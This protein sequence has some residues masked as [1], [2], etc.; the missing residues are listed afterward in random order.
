MLP[1]DQN[2]RHP[3]IFQNDKQWK[4]GVAPDVYFLGLLENVE[5]FLWPHTY[6]STRRVILQTS[7]NGE[8]VLLKEECPQML[9]WQNCVFS[10]TQHV[11][12]IVVNK[13]VK[14]KFPA[15]RINVHIEHVRHY[16][17]QDSFLKP[18]KENDQKRKPKRKVAGLNGKTSLLHP[19]KY[20]LW[21]AM[22]RSQRC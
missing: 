16:R 9:P 14:G 1:L 12:G 8:W 7:G 19:E 22:D 3:I 5:L 13:Q 15:K 11:T 2:H 10:I 6:E 21:E 18:M 20:T 4:R 17:S